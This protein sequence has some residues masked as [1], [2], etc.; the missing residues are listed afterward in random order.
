MSQAYLI[1]VDSN[2]Y[3]PELLELES[4]RRKIRRATEPNNPN[5]LSRFFELDQIQK[6]SSPIFQ[7]LHAKR[8]CTLLLETIL[9]DSLAPQWREH[10]LNL[11]HRPLSIFQR[12]S[13]TREN[14][15]EISA[16]FSSLRNVRIY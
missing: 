7:K 6:N 10:C 3:K 12:L 1:D 5:L 2:S 13:D 4:I 15:L 14:N 11:I 9:D 16:I 8:Q